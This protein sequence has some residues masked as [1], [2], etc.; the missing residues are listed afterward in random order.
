MSPLSLEICRLD[1]SDEEAAL[2]ALGCVEVQCR[3]VRDF[4][5]QALHQ[6]ENGRWRLELRLLNAG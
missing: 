6:T 4:V 5:L 1:P 2:G 3:W